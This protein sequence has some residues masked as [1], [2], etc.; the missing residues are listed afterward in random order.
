MSQYKVQLE[1]RTFREV[2]TVERQSVTVDAETLEDAE[3]K[4]IEHTREHQWQFWDT[5][6]TYENDPFDPEVIRSEDRI[7]DHDWIA[8]GF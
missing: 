8:D 6:I 7:A 5:E 2:V 4:A 1:R 3:E